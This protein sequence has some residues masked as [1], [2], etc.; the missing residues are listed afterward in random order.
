VD[1]KICIIT[2]AN[3]G[4]GK[5]AAIQI[6]KKGYH[7]ILACRNQSRGEA[8]LNHIIKQ[9]KSNSVELMILDMS[10]QSSIQKFA[11]AFLKK[12]DRLDV[13]IHN[14]A[15]FDI[16]VKNPIITQDGIESI[17]AT[18]HLGPVLMTQLLLDALLN[19]MQGRIITIASKGLVTF[20]FIQVNL[21]DPEFKKRKFS[22]IKA[23]YQS[24]LAQVM[25]TYWL[26][27]KLKGTNVTV[28]CI[29]VT[30]VKLDISRYPNISEISKLMYLIKSRFSL[31]TGDMAKVY[32]YLAVSDSVSK[33]SGKYFD[34]KSQI[35]SSNKYSRDINNINK[36]MNLT[37]KYLKS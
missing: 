13:L 20:P 11:Q 4:I 3:S 9:S 10:L 18:N 31:S 16:S 14:A 21:D 22:V 25:Y 37:M 29:R 32:T 8:A 2:G 34:E 26:S 7:V 24:K 19:S 12:Y 5:A 28:N 23:Y 33:V 30:N 35:V 15:S 36:V 1:K 27:D 17:W 6:A